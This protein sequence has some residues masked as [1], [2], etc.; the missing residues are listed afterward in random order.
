MY[1]IRSYY[2]RLSMT[3]MN[4]LRLYEIAARKKA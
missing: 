4:E 3:L 2:V 1:A